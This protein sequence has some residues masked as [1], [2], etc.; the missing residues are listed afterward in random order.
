[1]KEETF[2]PVFDADYPAGVQTCQHGPYVKFKSI[3]RTATE[4]IMTFT[5]RCSFSRSNECSQKLTKKVFYERPE[6]ANRSWE[7]S[8]MTNKEDKAQG[9]RLHFFI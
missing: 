9:N 5:Y 4:P 2:E 6:V 7:E 3:K 8:F 1:M